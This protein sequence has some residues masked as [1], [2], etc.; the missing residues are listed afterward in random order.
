MKLKKISLFLVFSVLIFISIHALAAPNPAIDVSYGVHVENLGW[1]DPVKNMEV[2]GTTGQSRQIEAIKISA[3]LP[4]GSTL[5]Y[6]SHISDIGWEEDWKSNDEISGTVGENRKLEA[7]RIKIDGTD[8]SV[9]D[10]YYRSHVSN[11]GWLGWAKNGEE[12]GSTGLNRKLE[13]IQIIIVDK[14][15]EAPGSTE[16]AYVYNNMDPINTA[17]THISD[18]GWV[19]SEYIDTMIG[20]TG[21]SKDI[22]AL[23]L[24]YED[25]GNSGIEYRSHIANKGWEENFVGNGQMSG[26][27]GQGLPIEAIELRLTGDAATKYDIYYQAHCSNYGWLDWAKNGQDAGTTGCAERLEALNIVLVPKGDEAPGSTDEPYKSPIDHA[28]FRARINGCWMEDQKANDSSKSFVVGLSDFYLTCGYNQTFNGIEGYYEILSAN[29]TGGTVRVVDQ[30]TNEVK[31]V[32]ISFQDLANNELMIT[33]DGKS[34]KVIKGDTTDG[35]HYTFSGVLQYG[36]S[37]VVELKQGPSK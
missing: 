30:N 4:S 37:V 32:H 25:E 35:V 5:S 3:D 12:S 13:A 31:V 23:K 21:Q 24:T 33:V 2:A 36:Q 15:A 18:I 10:V 28:S 16:R 9:Y 14:G 29:T 20:T 6:Q 26:T 34:H 11:V 27:T 22:E 17:E 7:I 19:A 1:M 8:S